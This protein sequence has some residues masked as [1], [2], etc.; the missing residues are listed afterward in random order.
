M[1]T[2]IISLR[3]KKKLYNYWTSGP[4]VIALS[5]QPSW[6]HLPWNGASGTMAAGARPSCV[7]LT[8]PF[9]L[10]EPWP[11]P[12]GLWYLLVLAIAGSGI[13]GGGRQQAGAGGREMR[14]GAGHM[15]ADG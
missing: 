7:D 3:K 4:R 5:A 13:T 10:S 14:A 9:F 1:A 8:R 11:W 6:R 12:F 2:P 15:D